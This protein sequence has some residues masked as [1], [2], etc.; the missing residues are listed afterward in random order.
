MTKG[1]E[2]AGHDPERRALIEVAN[3][4]LAIAALLEVFAPEPFVPE[5]GVHPT[6]VV[7]ASASL[8]RDCRVGPHV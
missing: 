5:I 3:A 8:G 7:D 6:A 1:V 2:P 4:E